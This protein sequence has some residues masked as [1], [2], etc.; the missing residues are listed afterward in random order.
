MV[1]FAPNGAL[2]A[3]L[4]ASGTALG[5]A[6]GGPRVLVGWVKPGVVDTSHIIYEGGKHA[7]AYVEARCEE[8]VLGDTK[9]CVRTLTDP[10]NKTVGTLV[11]SPTKGCECPLIEDN[12]GRCS[13]S[14]ESIRMTCRVE[15]EGGTQLARSSS[16][17]SSCSLGW[18]QSETGQDTIFVNPMSS[19]TFYTVLHS[20]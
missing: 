14:I 12:S 18:N 11:S 7:M 6:L 9:C 15:S 8:G 16:P 4:L 20:D 3:L 17:K 5:G 19:F 1:R 13:A 10:N 2:V